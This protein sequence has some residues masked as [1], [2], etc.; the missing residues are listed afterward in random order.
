MLTLNDGDSKV[1]SAST[2][3]INEEEN[4]LILSLDIIAVCL[5]NINL[6][7]N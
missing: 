2:L 5:E 6:Y 1:L 7:Q 4:T 3:T